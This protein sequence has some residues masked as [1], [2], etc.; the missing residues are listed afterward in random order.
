MLPP[1][2]MNVRTAATGLTS[3]PPLG[4]YRFA[5]ALLLAGLSQVIVAQP[6]TPTPPVPPTA[7]KPASTPNRIAKP[8]WK[9]LTPEQQQALK[10][11]AAHW[12]PLNAD[13]K[14]KWL[15]VSKN[16]PA[17]STVEQ[18]KLHS[19]MREWAL[20]GQQQRNQARLNFAQT[21]N[22]TAEEKAAQWQAYQALS[23]EEKRQLAAK[24]PAK[25]VGAAAVKPLPP[26]KLTVIPVTRHT[27]KE[28]APPS[29]A[30]AIDRNTLL[31]QP[32]A[33]VEPAPASADNS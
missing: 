33:P 20:L 15:E 2:A 30:R 14:R 27:P 29:A 12:D 21:Q 1:L 8:T 31:P 10:P 19:R 7:N 22:L 25:P 5:C 3:L 24:A 4:T 6:A 9:E 13:R 18:A 28:E 32:Q 17:L 11:L 23:P 16:Y 26:Q